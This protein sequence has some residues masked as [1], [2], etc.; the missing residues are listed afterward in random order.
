MDVYLRYNQIG[1]ADKDLS[2]TAFYANNDIYHYVVLP[3]RLINARSNNQRMANR[4]SPN[5]LGDIM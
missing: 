2:H 5:M 3:F 4:I 1:I